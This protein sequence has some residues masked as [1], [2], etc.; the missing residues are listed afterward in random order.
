MATRHRASARVTM[1]TECSPTM[2]RAP[3]QVT[4]ERRGY[5]RAS[6]ICW[7]RNADCLASDFRSFN[8]LL[9]STFGV[10]AIGCKARSISVIQAAIGALRATNLSRSK[11]ALDGEGGSTAPDVPEL[12]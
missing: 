9:R 3:R 12:R 11:V 2:S 6:A 8:N 5:H 4:R 1:K 7:S 10:C